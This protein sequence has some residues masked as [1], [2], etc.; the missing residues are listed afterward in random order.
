MSGAGQ[1]D[2]SGRA[3]RGRKTWR[4]AGRGR[5]ARRGGLETTRS[6]SG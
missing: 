6:G 2:R 5:P 3:G 1:G 4:R